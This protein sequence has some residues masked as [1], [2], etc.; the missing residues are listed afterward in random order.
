MRVGSVANW[1]IFWVRVAGLIVVEWDRYA[2]IC[3]AEVSRSD[4]ADSVCVLL[5][6]LGIFLCQAHVQCSQL[7]TLWIIQV[8]WSRPIASD[9]NCALLQIPGVIQP[10][11]L[12]SI[13][14]NL[15]SRSGMILWRVTLATYLIRKI[16][17]ICYLEPPL[18]GLY[19]VRK[20]FDGEF[21][22]LNGACSF[23]EVCICAR[24]ERACSST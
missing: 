9:K 17:Q 5:P 15:S 22:K 12:S 18:A 20:T 1:S 10:L 6:D 23:A 4:L 16:I 14:M 21:I 3:S 24:W 7:L 11:V 8:P 19:L 2:W 13:G